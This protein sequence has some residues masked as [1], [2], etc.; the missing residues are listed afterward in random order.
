MTQT[1]H[2]LDEKTINQIAAGEVIENAASVIKELVD[3]A[4]D[5]K[6]SRIQ[7]TAR[8]SGRQSIVVQD[9]GLGM[10]KEDLLLCLERHA[11]SKIAS[12]NDLWK[13]STMGFRGEALS[14]ISSISRVSI[15]TCRN[16]MPEQ[17]ESLGQGHFLKAQGGTTTSC[18]PAQA[19]FGT[20]V[21]VENLFYNTPARQK[22][23]QSLQKEEKAIFKT[24]MLLAMSRPDIGF[25][26]IINGKKELNV[27]PATY[28][29]RSRELLG[30]ES[31][32]QHVPFSFENE[33]VH[34]H[35]FLSKPT[36]SKPNR[37]SQY[38]FV[39]ARPVTSLQVSSWIKQGY[40]SSIEEARH[41]SFVLYIDLQKDLVDVNVH[42]QKKEVRLAHEIELKSIFMQKIRDTLFFAPQ[43]KTE[44]PIAA[45]AA[46]TYH[47]TACQMPLHVFPEP[48]ITEEKEPELFQIQTPS[49][50]GVFD[51]YILARA[52]L[53]PNMA[54]ELDAEGLL[55]IHSRNAF[56][57]VAYEESLKTSES[58]QSQQLLVP[59]FIE[60]SVHKAHAIRN[61]LEE[62]IQAGIQ[63]REFGE[64]AFLVEAIPPYLDNIDLDEFLHHV[65]SSHNETTTLL[66]CRQAF[67]KQAARF[68][69]KLDLGAEMAEI[70]VKKLF[71][72]DDPF[73]CPLGNKTMFTISHEV[74]AKYV[75]S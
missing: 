3:N 30:A 43:Q 47:Y 10:T 45:T 19:L 13:L 58:I 17:H 54:V 29:E 6:A 51:P 66:E 53:M 16:T 57:R 28:A 74:L 20:K 69:K 5:A 62:M 55:F 27:D 59:H 39:N 4:I 7:I 25:E 38:L 31:T 35:G 49:V 24:V 48:Q 40:G 68:S 11:T 36:F 26:L 1:I 44:K 65:A 42:P 61:C 41:P 50:I 21:E 22:F 72:C 37:M 2:V 70:L 14:A 60:M 15:L 63:I 71:T 52:S 9:N 46:T 73:H 12:E 64:N 23:V 32:S 33:W 67:M 34:I 18:S 8:A 56:A 75:S